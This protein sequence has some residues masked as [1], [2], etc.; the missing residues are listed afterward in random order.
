MATVADMTLEQLKQLINDELDQRLT[1]VLGN[2]DAED[3]DEAE[4]GLSWEE[5]R[6]RV[7]QHRWTPPT[8]AKSSIDFLREDRE[9]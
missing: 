9:S 2:L 3:G 6:R 5:I 1:R 7:E 4:A 8:G